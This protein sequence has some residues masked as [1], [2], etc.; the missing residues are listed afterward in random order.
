MSRE[1]AK[2]V[3]HRLSKKDLFRLSACTRCG[4]CLAY[5]PVYEQTADESITARAKIRETQRMI[6]T[7]IGLLA[8]I[9]GPKEISEKELKE[10][11]GRLASC[12]GCAACA[13]YC[14]SDIS[15]DD[16]WIHLRFIPGLEYTNGV[17]IS[18]AREEVKRNHITRL[19]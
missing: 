1:P 7:Q 6:R 19:Q 15:T 9:R 3:S 10:V 11:Y 16:L 12:T 18:C 8:K 13:T 2:S 5:C 14:P 17:C 4:D